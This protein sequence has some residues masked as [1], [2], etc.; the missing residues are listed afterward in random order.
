MFT[1]ARVMHTVMYLSGRQPWRTLAYGV[2][3]L[4]LSGLA[5]LLGAGL[6]TIKG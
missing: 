2:G 4:C 1:A 6:I 5:G 3:V